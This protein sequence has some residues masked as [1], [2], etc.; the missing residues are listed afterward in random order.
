MALLPFTK[1]IKP[2]YLLWIMGL[3]LAA[4]ILLKPCQELFFLQE[5]VFSS[6]NK[7]F[8]ANEK[9]HGNF[10]DQILST[11]T[12]VSTAD[13]E[14]MLGNGSIFLV[15]EQ[16]DLLFC[17]DELRSL[18][19]S[20]FENGNPEIQRL[21]GTDYLFRSKTRDSFT[22]VSVLDIKHT[23][24]NIEFQLLEEEEWGIDAIQVTKASFLIRMISSFLFSVFLIC[25]FFLMQGVMISRLS[26]TKWT[27]L[28][29]FSIII[30]ARILASILWAFLTKT[31]L[32]KHI[33]SGGVMNPLLNLAVLYWLSL[34]IPRMLMWSR[35]RKRI[36][37]FANYF[38]LFLLSCGYGTFVQ[39]AL[40]FKNPL[41]ENSGLFTM[42]ASGVLFYLSILLIGLITFT[43]SF[44]LI[45]NSVQWQT[46]VKEKL[47]SFSLAAVLGF[48]VYY[49]SD[50]SLGF[51][52]IL[53]I[54]MSLS[55]L[56]D[57]F[58]D[59][60]RL[61]FAWIISWV[62]FLSM[63]TVLFIFHVHHLQDAVMNQAAAHAISEAWTEK[64]SLDDYRYG[65]LVESV[66]SKTGLPS[67]AI[68]EEGRKAYSEGD[69]FPFALS[70]KSNLADVRLDQ[71]EHVVI[72]KPSFNRVRLVS[73][74]SYHFGLLSIVLLL[75]SLIHAYYPFLHFF[76]PIRFRE[77]SSL[78][79]KIQSAIIASILFSFAIIALLTLVFFR[80]H[81]HESEEKDMYDKIESLRDKQVIK[82]RS[83]SL[84]AQIQVGNPFAMYTA[85]GKALFP[86][87]AAPEIFPR[88][89][90]SFYPS[91][92]E[93]EGPRDYLIIEDK[94]QSVKKVLLAFDNDK[95]ELA[96]I[97]YM[98]LPSISL[99]SRP[100]LDR[101]VTTLVNVYLFLFL[102]AAAV[103][104]FLSDSITRPLQALRQRLKSFRLGR[105]NEALQWSNNDEI[106]E[107]IKN[108]NELIVTVE[109]S[110]NILASNERDMAWR[111]MARQVAHEIKNPLTPMKLRVQHLQHSMKVRPE[112]AEQM[113]EQ[114][115]ATIIEQ[116]DNLAHI[117][118]EFSNFGKMPSARN[119]KIILNDVVSSVHDLF[120]KRE[121][122]YVNL[123][124]PL[125]EIYVFADR[126]HL[127]RILTNL[128]KNAIQ[129]IP[130][131]KQ[132]RIDIRLFKKEGNALISVKDN[133]TG[134]PAEMQ[135]KVF[136]PNFTTK[137]SGTGLGLA[138]CSSLVDLFNGKLYFNTM[139]GEGTEF[140]VEIPLM[141]LKD[142]YDEVQ[143]VEL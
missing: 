50:L 13:A 100:I 52:P 1:K 94:N 136:S 122:L 27:P 103:A 4:L 72:F 125:D 45:H 134:I 111:E 5:S 40:A 19:L 128:I 139:E 69:I 36:W 68:Y 35:K 104:I 16:S 38:F 62:I 80:N 141:R 17:S 31:E 60:I 61:S 15:L 98:P 112:D 105:N 30:I 6:V 138:I 10:Y 59:Y 83:Q 47:I 3:S 73:L 48:A 130:Q 78:A 7:S 14:K 85:D 132:G 115:A 56:V 118:S 33:F 51:A 120:R 79:D 74:F 91:F 77:K 58:T 101:F 9:A 76:I 124:T 82:N 63:Y 53:L 86:A 110:A 116:I 129:A 28:I 20:S 55:L 2:L 99:R 95:G 66:E 106:G 81:F 96:Q 113:V 43:V 22:L 21:K 32:D 135:E 29:W 88:Q 23:N 133:G 140:F 107:L 25:A 121:D 34:S 57:L 49:F 42:N 54:C 93:E 46:N 70:E 18:D 11:S 97:M 39:S 84:E 114:V 89:L 75:C 131:D 119:E 41:L 26:K 87:T 64:E 90:S 123:Y 12:K 142:N 71:D 127:I 65:R 117:A 24:T 108:Y 37:V 67:F 102:I 92:F 126:Y 137:N 109:N 44:R 8:E 143:R